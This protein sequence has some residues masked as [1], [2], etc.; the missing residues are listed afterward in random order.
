MKDESD[1][2]NG[3]NE[4]SPIAWKSIIADTSKLL[5]YNICCSIISI[6][7]KWCKPHETRR[8]WRNF[9]PWINDNQ[10]LK[11]TASKSL[12]LSQEAKNA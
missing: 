5:Q 7:Y 11:E 4:F 6:F 8:R 9:A 12:K 1:R 3:E 2:I 10:L